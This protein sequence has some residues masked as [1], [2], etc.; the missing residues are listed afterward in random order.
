MKTSNTTKGKRTPTTGT[1][2]AATPSALGASTGGAS[3]HT[4]EVPAENDPFF[5]EPADPIREG[6]EQGVEVICHLL[7]WM[8][9]A[10]TLEKRGLRATIA[11][12]CIRPDLIHGV[13]L[14]KIGQQAGCTRKCLV[15]TPTHCP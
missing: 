10:T 9:E 13:T 12:Y 5:A 14:E 6:R 4:T 2:T 1:A 15:R 8:A 11:L 3:K 7:I